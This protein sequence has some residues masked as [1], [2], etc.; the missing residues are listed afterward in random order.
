MYTNMSLKIDVSNFKLNYLLNYCDTAAVLLQPTKG[1]HPTLW[2]SL[3]YKI[4]A[5]VRNLKTFVFLDLM[6]KSKVVNYS[7]PWH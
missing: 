3:H 4:H 7:I 1:P 5:V 6:S 2:E